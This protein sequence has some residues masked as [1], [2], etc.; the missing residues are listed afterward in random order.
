MNLGMPGLQAPFFHPQLLEHFEPGQQG[1]LC[2]EHPQFWLQLSNDTETRTFK[3]KGQPLLYL[4]LHKR[5]KLNFSY[6]RVGIEAM[7]EFLAFSML[8]LPREVREPLV[9]KKACWSR[10]RDPYHISFP[11]VGT[12]PHAPTSVGT[13]ASWPGDFSSWELRRH[14]SK[15]EYIKMSGAMRH[16]QKAS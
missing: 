14:I 2:K 15:G 6:S 13:V 1:R 3:G 16:I 7:R 9:V 12:V 10:A 5:R 11:P 4:M 8:E